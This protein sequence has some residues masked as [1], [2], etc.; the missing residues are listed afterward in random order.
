MSDPSGELR[1]LRRRLREVYA[2]A[3]Y[4][5]PTQETLDAIANV[6]ASED[7]PEATDEAP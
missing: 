5:E 2:L 4:G 1:E 7:D 6:A 3:E